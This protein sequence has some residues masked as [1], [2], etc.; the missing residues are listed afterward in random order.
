MV[1]IAANNKFIAAV[2]ATPDIKNCYQSGLKAMGSYS[3]K[4]S[5]SNTS[6][7][8]GSVDI[9]EC[10][11]SEYPNANRWDYCFGYNNKAY[12][13]EVHSANTS[14]VSTML[15]K[16]Q[17]LKDWLNSSAPELNKIKA[18]PPYYWVMSGKY[19]ILPNSPQAKRIAQAGLKPISKLSL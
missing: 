1:K 12:F 13:V 3:T 7:C 15:N 4:I 8:N 5:L 6:S 16:L 14:E 18:N 17:W 19:D 9:D 11:K 2:D 10:V